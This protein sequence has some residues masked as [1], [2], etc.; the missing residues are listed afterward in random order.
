[1]VWTGSTSTGDDHYFAGCSIDG[2]VE[3]V[4]RPM[5]AEFQV[6]IGEPDQALDVI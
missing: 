3:V 2:L 4:P 1:M 6:R 5:V